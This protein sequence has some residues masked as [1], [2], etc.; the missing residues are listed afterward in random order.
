MHSSAI[1]LN[2]PLSALSSPGLG[3]PVLG[4]LFYFSSKQ[5]ATKVMPAARRLLRTVLFCAL[6]AVGLSVTGCDSSGSNDSPE[7]VGDWE[8]VDDNVVW[9]ITEDQIE[10]F[11]AV[12]VSGTTSCTVLTVDIT[13]VDGNTVSGED[14]NGGERTATFNVNDDGQ[15]V[16]DF[17][18]RAT[19]TFD[20]IDGG[21]EDALG[22]DVV[23]D[24]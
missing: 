16:A 14:E 1:T 7:W 18:N 4:S 6:V 5:V 12:T 9:S 20:P 11:E 21:P 24:V 22:C 8:S 15:L 13:N 10:I 19:Q 3:D 17:E 23:T 2:H